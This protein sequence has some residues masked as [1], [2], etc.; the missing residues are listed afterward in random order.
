MTVFISKVVL[1]LFI[2]N[3]LT[4]QVIAEQDVAPEN[5]KKKVLWVSNKKDKDKDLTFRGFKYAAKGKYVLQYISID[6]NVI[7]QLDTRESSFDF[8]IASGDNAWEL[9]ATSNHNVA[10]IGIGLNQSNIQ[11]YSTVRRS[12]HYLIAKEQAPQRIFAMMSVLDLNHSQAAAL[13]NKNQIQEKFEFYKQSKVR[14]LPFKAINIQK[15]QNILKIIASVQDCCRILYL[16]DSDFLLSPEKIKSILIESYRR[17]IIVI[18]NHPDML[19]L[20]AMYVIYT[21]DHEL[22]I[23]AASTIQSLINNKDIKPVQRPKEFV[24]DSN[25]TLRKL[26][27]GSL[28]N[29]PIG[30]LLNKTKLLDSIVDKDIEI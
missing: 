30:D 9:I 28:I 10:L 15:N 19:K 4:F 6:S 2:N 29:Q 24:I 18:G 11:K 1:L 13:F 3:G 14:G 7:K 25:V 12:N 21:P 16:K 20:G 26:I 5:T 8:I 27:G 22:G 17:R 23:Q